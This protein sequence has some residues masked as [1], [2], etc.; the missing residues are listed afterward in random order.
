[1]T[2]SAMVQRVDGCGGRRERKKPAQTPLVDVNVVLALSRRCGREQTGPLNVNA[3][4]L[5]YERC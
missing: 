1:M 2:V 5:F 3:Q 4:R